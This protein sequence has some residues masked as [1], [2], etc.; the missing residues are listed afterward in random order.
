MWELR[1]VGVAV[2]GSFGLWGLWCVQFADGEAVLWA[3]YG[4]GALGG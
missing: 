1:Y 3:G 2:C 4:A